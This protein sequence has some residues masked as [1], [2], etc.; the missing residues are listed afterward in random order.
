MYGMAGMAIVVTSHDGGGASSQKFAKHLDT[1][2][3]W[4]PIVPA[5]KSKPLRTSATS[6]RQNENLN[7]L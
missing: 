6:I 7:H 1:G 4:N 5:S 2:L 3:D